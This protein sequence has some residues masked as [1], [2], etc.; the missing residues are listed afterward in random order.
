MF[1]FK[2]SNLKNNLRPFFHAE[3]NKDIKCLILQN[4]KPYII[5]TTK[6]LKEL[7]QKKNDNYFGI[8]ILCY[9]DKKLLS[10]LL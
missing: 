9:L 4:F 10:K 7:L 3:Y 8:E 2:I 6:L 5:I 1:I